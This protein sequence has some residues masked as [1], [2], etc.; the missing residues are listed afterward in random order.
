MLPPHTSEDY[1]IEDLQDS[2][3]NLL[4]HQARLMRK[5][6]DIQA[7]LWDLQYRFW[8]FASKEERKRD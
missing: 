1:D 3:D 6:V 5:Q 2:L 8:V 4:K 7:V